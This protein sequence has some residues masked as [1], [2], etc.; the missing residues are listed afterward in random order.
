ME[1]GGAKAERTELRELLGDTEVAFSVYNFSLCLEGS[2][3]QGVKGRAEEQS[4]EWVRGARKCGGC[5]L[6]ARE[7]GPGC[8]RTGFLRWEY[9]EWLQAGRRVWRQVKGL[10]L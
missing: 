9:R 5:G 10:G 3:L 8:L 6:W 2:T 7:A 4:L 1:G